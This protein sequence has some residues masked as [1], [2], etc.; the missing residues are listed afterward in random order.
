LRKNASQLWYDHPVAT[1]DSADRKDRDR[2]ARIRRA[3]EAGVAALGG[4]S[5]EQR[6]RK[7][8]TSA[9]EWASWLHQELEIRGCTNPT[10]ILPDALARLEQIA[11]DRTA[12]AIRSLKASLR[13][14]LLR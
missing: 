1:L 5:V 13:K 11:E 14:A 4:Q 9:D 12:T 10:E 3:K 7:R 6:T 8:E 2:R